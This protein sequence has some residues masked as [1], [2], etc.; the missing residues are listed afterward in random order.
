[1]DV[2]RFPP[3]RG[4]DYMAYH[5]KL[6]HEKQMFHYADYDSKEEIAYSIAFPSFSLPF[7]TRQRHDIF[8]VSIEYLLPKFILYCDRII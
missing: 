2:S 8:S 6:G 7:L 4:Y 5:G 3:L 1:M